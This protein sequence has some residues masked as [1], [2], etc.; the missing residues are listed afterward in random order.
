MRYLYGDAS[1]FPLN[2]NFIETIVAIVEACVVL[3]VEDDAAVE[4]RKVADHAR[5]KAADEL[6]KLQLLDQ[7]V[8]RAVSSMLPEQTPQTR[9]ELAAVRITKSTAA[10]I[11]QARTGITKQRDAAMLKALRRGDPKRIRHAVE[12]F[13]V[14]HELPNTRWSVR[15]QATGA[16]PRAE[17]GASADHSV[18]VR[19]AATIA[20]NSMWSA[21]IPL[22]RFDKELTLPVERKVGWLR[23]RDTVVRESTKKMRI[24]LVE[25]SRDRD[26]LVVEHKS[27][28]PDTRLH[29]L[30]RG[31]EYAAPVVT[32][33]DEAGKRAGRPIV[34]TPDDA[35]GLATVWS[36]IESELSALVD[37]RAS[38]LEVFLDNTEIAN[39]ERPAEFAEA[40]LANIAP[41]VRE[42]RMRSSVHGELVLKRD[43]DSGRREELFLPRQRLQ[44]KYSALA[45]HYQSSF[46]DI[47][48]GTEATEEFAVRDLPL[49]AETADTNNGYQPVERVPTER[50]PTTPLT[51]AM[52]ERLRTSS[53]DPHSDPTVPIKYSDDEAA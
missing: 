45:D 46:A 37:A 42:M 12:S 15:W 4:R 32:P 52:A 13:F 29:I 49:I 7:W 47:G 27:G 19:L 21:A 36:A 50:T 51:P 5:T 33:I 22:A 25:K 17:I 53:V 31:G 10:A 1:P 43:L 30:L 23:K 40:L 24:I 44:H 39:L 35:A 8:E 38:V 28:R 3:F 6:A 48:L 18:R 34:V 9:C 2:E 26:A 16:A 14:R 20:N 41:F 11:D